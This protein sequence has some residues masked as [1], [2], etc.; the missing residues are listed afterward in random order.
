MKATSSIPYAVTLLL[1]GTTLAG[2]FLTD[3][4]G[5]TPLGRPLAQIAPEL[6]GWTQ[7]AD[8]PLDSAV[9]EQLKPTTYLSRVYGK[10]EQRLGLLVIYYAQQRAGETIKKIDQQRA[11]CVRIAA[12]W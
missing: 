10:A 11:S 3:R 2:A 4:Q 5:V 9:L 8:A 1:M 12:S 6:S 7:V